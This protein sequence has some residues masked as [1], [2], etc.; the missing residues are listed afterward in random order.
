MPD[1]NQQHQWV[2]Q[3]QEQAGTYYFS[4]QFFVTPGVQEL[5]TKEEIYRIYTEVLFYAEQEKGLDYLQVF[6]RESDKQRL[7]FIDQL[8]QEMIEGGVYDPEDNHCVLMLAEEY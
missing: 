8:N 5:L 4:G 7:F 6:L 3:P 1:K 2:R